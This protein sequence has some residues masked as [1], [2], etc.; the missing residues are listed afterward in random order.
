M[1]QDL[2]SVE[3]E[4]EVPAIE[5]RSRSRRMRHKKPGPIDDSTAG[6]GDLAPTDE[7]T[8][9]EDAPADPDIPSVAP[10]ARSWHRQHRRIAFGLIGLVAVAAIAV[11]VVVAS[12]GGGSGKTS[13]TTPLSENPVVA[14]YQQQ[15]PALAAAVTASPTDPKALRA[16][17][18]ALYATGDVNRAKDEYEAELKVNQSDPVLLNNLGNVYRDLGTYDKALEVY[19]RSISLDSTT[20]TAYMNLANLYQYTLNQKD[21]GIKTLQAALVN[22]PDNQDLGVLLGIANEQNGDKDAASAAFQQVLK[23]NPENAAA[24]AGVARLGA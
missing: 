21:L 18:V 10:R 22:M 12:S 8:P 19:Q 20:P 5:P 3:S 4:P 23:L 15:L 16:Y 9:S 24:K 14:S 7:I 17:G 6:K 2:N 11:V 1:K 13:G